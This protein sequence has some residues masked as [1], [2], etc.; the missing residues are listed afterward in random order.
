MNLETKLSIAL[1]LISEQTG[2]TL[3]DLKPLK[4][5][6]VNPQTNEL[7]DPSDP[8]WDE[9][10]A[11][12]EAWTVEEILNAMMP[13]INK[14]SFDVSRAIRGLDKEDVKQDLSLWLITN[15]LDKNE[16]SPSG[17]QDQGA[18]PF[19]SFAFR[20]LKS[21][22]YQYGASG[23][24]RGSMSHGRETF[25]QQT[26]MST[27]AG[28]EGQGTLGDMLSGKSEDPSSVLHNKEIFQRIMDQASLTPAEKIVIN[29]SYGLEDIDAEALGIQLSAAGKK[30]R[31]AVV[32][33]AGKFGRRAGL[34][35]EV[36]GSTDIAKIINRTEGYY[37]TLADNKFTAGRVQPGLLSLQ[38]VEKVPELAAQN[39]MTT[40]EKK[41][42]P[43]IWITTK[44][45][46]NNIRNSAAQK[47]IDAAEEVAP[48]EFET[49]QVQERPEPTPPTSPTAVRGAMQKIE[50]EKPVWTGKK[51][52]KQ[53]GMREAIQKIVSHLRCYLI[54]YYVYGPD[55]TIFG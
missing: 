29:L 2:R 52:V 32:Q 35:G 53:P 21:R 55:K 46:V 48:E 49:G 37:R 3:G 13:Y 10:R 47:I 28:E 6:H 38:P 27:P 50:R 14:L 24:A 17:W 25:V 34:E 41:G 15:T 23:S 33:K 39:F 22:A 54:E 51:W 30:A 8:N 5:P 42:Q 9:A 26:S 11:T 36:W 16:S 12:G 18:A 4:M 7:W 1:G 45:M 44:Q 40:G 43:A 20:R 19:S 31:S